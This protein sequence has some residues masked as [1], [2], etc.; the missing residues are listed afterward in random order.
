LEPSK[1]ARAAIAEY[2]DILD[3]DRTRGEREFYKQEAERLARAL[4][5]IN[6]DKEQRRACCA[7]VADAIAELEV[8]A[9]NR[10][11]V[12]HPKTKRAKLVAGRL[13]DALRKVEVLAHSKD[14]G[15]F[16]QLAFPREMISSWIE[17]CR[18]MEREPT[19]LVARDDSKK[20]RAAERAF[21]LLR[22]QGRKVVTTNNSV[23]CQLATV[24]FGKPDADLEH[25]CREVKKRFG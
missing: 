24:L 3:G 18:E 19:R 15:V 6:P 9:A 16:V 17:H 11:W 8:D 12:R 20:T 25:V 23:F 21:V 10:Y 5:L 13:L 1:G 2:I 4:D 7:D 14:Q 22:R